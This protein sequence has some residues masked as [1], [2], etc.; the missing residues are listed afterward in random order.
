MVKEKGTVFCELN[1]IMPLFPLNLFLNPQKYLPTIQTMTWPSCQWLLLGLILV[2][3][4]CHVTGESVRE[5]WDLLNRFSTTLGHQYSPGEWL[6]TFLPFCRAGHLILFSRI[7]NHRSV[8]A[9]NP[10]TGRPR[11]SML[12]AHTSPLPP[13]HMGSRVGQPACLPRGRSNRPALT[14]YL[15]CI[16]SHLA[17]NKASTL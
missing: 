3:S 8:A 14:I 11:G 6:K 1:F 12:T 4:P 5:A 7:D 17:P 13:P 10:L 2:T 9:A 15:S 16:Y